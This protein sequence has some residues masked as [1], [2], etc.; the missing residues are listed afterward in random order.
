MSVARCRRKSWWMGIVLG[1]LAGS[2]TALELELPLDPLDAGSNF[3]RIAGFGY[4]V[5]EHRL[6]GHPGLDFEYK[7]G[8]KV[9][10][11][12][13]GRLSYFVDAH[14]PSKLTVQ[15]EF[16]AD[17]KNWRNVYTNLAALEPGLV[18]GSQ[19]STGQALGSAGSVTA[20][21]GNTTL[22]YAMTH[23]QLDDLSG[24]VN[25]GLSNPTALSPIPYF[26]AT[27]QAAFA[28][29]VEP[30]TYHQQLCEPFMSTPRGLLPY[31][32]LTRTW[33][34]QQGSHVTRL[35]FSCDH[36]SNQSS[37]RYA[38]FDAS[39]ALLETGTVITESGASALPTIEFNPT[40]GGKRLGV[41][42]VN[43]NSGTLSLDYS[44]PGGS[45][46][47][48]INNA[49]RYGTE[50]GATACATASDALCLVGE[51]SPY[52]NGQSLSLSLAVHGDRLA[53]APASVDLWGAPASPDGAL[54]FFTPSGLSPTPAA[55]R[56]ALDLRSGQG[57]IVPLLANVTITPA[58]AGRF[59]FFGLAAPVGTPVEQLL[60]RRLGNLLA[61]T[62]AIQP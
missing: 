34:L 38:L 13:A 7:L 36:A 19:V 29:L 35:D 61:V 42:A 3:L 60:E 33:R 17:G 31:P 43:A 37:Y 20:Q 28:A 47:L 16:S 25:Y 15:I 41:Y 50:P 49:S 48:S 26:S 54:W 12:H 56:G 58:L 10:A 53:G 21:R 51:A 52:R 4:H 11:A 9:R 57:T 23:F 5:A 1:L 32:S 39:D 30:V 2:T 8:A 46:P 14:D 40:T 55:W 22:T 44:A 6:D 27:A 18:Q 62:T 24:A 45:R 59:I